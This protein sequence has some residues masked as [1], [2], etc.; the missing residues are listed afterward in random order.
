MSEPAEGYGD[1]ST[2]ADV[3]RDLADNFIVRP[4]RRVV[5]KFAKPEARTVPPPEALVQLAR[6][7][8]GLPSELDPENEEAKRFDLPVLRFVDAKLTSPSTRR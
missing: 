7:V 5:E 4:K 3:R 8:A 2:E 6:N 1:A